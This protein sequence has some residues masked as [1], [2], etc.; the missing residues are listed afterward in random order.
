MSENTENVKMQF[1]QRIRDGGCV[2][3]GT[4]QP[5]EDLEIQNIQ[6]PSDD[7]KGGFFYHKK[8]LPKVSVDFAQSMMNCQTLDDINNMLNS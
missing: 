7:Q 4:K 5:V 8:C 6:M 1:A 2:I 3:C